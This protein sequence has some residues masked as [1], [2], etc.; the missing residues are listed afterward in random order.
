MHS[1]D[2][3]PFH[4][5]NANPRKDKLKVKVCVNLVTN[6][7]RSEWLAKYSMVFPLNVNADQLNMLL[8]NDCPEKEKETSW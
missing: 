8:M 3:T 7:I 4:Q 6:I 2:N 1:I 5:F